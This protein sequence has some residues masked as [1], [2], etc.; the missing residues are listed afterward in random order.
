MMGGGVVALL[1]I[2]AAEWNEKTRG[3][4][5]EKKFFFCTFARKII[6]EITRRELCEKISS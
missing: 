5:S 2:A 6:E 3:R 1:P 4:A